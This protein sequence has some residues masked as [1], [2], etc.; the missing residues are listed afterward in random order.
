MKV[1]ITGASGKC[2]TALV[3]LPYE[4]I[5]F[6]R[7]EFPGL[8]KNGAFIRGGLDNAALLKE[9]M[10]GVDVL[11]HLAASP[12][13]ESTWDEVL[14]NNITGAQRVFQA[15]VESG[16]K[17][18]IFAGSNHIV[19]MY[20]LENAPGIYESGHGIMLDKNVE[21]RPDS[22]Y[23]VS[24]AFGEN[25]GRYY[26]EKGHFQ[27]LSIR[28]GAVLD[29]ENDHPFAYA[30]KGVERGEWERGGSRYLTMEK[31]LKAVWCSRRDFV[32]MVDLCIRYEKRH[33]DIFY[34]VSNNDRRWLDIGYAEKEL[35]YRPEDNAETWKTLQ[36]VNVMEKRK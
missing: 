8:L 26:A 4:N 16:V 5:Y 17:K 9:S 34:G 24:K 23:G 7:R 15:A 19:G 12:S 18:V 10:E 30:E 13:P 3:R 21:V 29:A 35:G 20:E 36:H 6:D 33:F 1:L 28:I 11:V 22:Y 2:G 32:Q 14:E 31:R 27:F 25:L